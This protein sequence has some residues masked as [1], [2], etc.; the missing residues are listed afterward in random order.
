[1][2]IYDV[3]NT[4]FPF[5]FDVNTFP[6]VKEQYDAYLQFW[7]NKYDEIVNCYCGSLFVGHCTAENLVEH[8]HEFEK[9]LNLDPSYLI[10]LVDMNGLSVNKSFEE[11]LVTELRDQDMQI[12]NIES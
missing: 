1:M 8:F 11:E 7:S 10:H 12:L 6:Q 3:N 9:F 2:L 4:P 5:K